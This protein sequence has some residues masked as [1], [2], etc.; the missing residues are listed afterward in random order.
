MPVVNRCN[1]WLSLPSH[2]WPKSTKKR[3]ASWEP[4][5]IMSQTQKQEA[6]GIVRERKTRE[7]EEKERDKKLRCKEGYAC[8]N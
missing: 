1:A 8:G 6:K 3:L 2:A 4:Q 7:E 5:K